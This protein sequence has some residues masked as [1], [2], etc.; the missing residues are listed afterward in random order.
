MLTY[1]YGANV[2]AQDSNGNTPLHLAVEKKPEQIEEGQ[3]PY[4]QI[5]VS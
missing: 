5:I 4:K 3:Q 1:T 2:N